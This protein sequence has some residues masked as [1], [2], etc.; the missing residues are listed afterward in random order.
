LLHHYG[1]VV[2]MKL[3]TPTRMLLVLGLERFDQLGGVSPVE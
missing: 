2:G 3:I 1:E